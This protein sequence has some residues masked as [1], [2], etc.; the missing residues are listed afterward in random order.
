MNYSVIKYLFRTLLRCSLSNQRTNR[1]MIM[2]M[3]VSEDVVLPSDNDICLGP[4]GDQEGDQVFVQRVVPDT[5]QL[6]IRLAS[7]GDRYTVEGRSTIL[8][9][10]LIRLCTIKSVDGAPIT[11]FVVHECEGSTRIGCRYTKIDWIT[12]ISSF[13]DPVVFCSREL[14]QEVC[15]CGI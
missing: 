1:R 11:S 9:D 13:Q 12:V 10:C 5:N 6:F 15:R 2:Q 14:Q 8:I 4:Y 3:L 7:N